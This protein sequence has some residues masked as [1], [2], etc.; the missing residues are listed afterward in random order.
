MPEGCA[1]GARRAPAC[2][3]GRAGGQG[4]GTR[5]PGAKQGLRH[6]DRCRAVHVWLGGFQG[7]VEAEAF[8][9]APGAFLRGLEGE[10][11]MWEPIGRLFET[12]DALIRPTWAVTGIAAGDPILGTL[13]EDG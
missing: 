2:G 10:Q 12:Y 5:R 8:A 9:N 3:S 1:P 6:Q 11:R 4:S 7:P 13:F